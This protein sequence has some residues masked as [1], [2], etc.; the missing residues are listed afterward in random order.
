MALDRDVADRVHPVVVQPLEDGRALVGHAAG[1]L[2]G[3]AHDAQR[4]GA[5]GGGVGGVGGS[6]TPV[7]SS[8]FRV[9]GFRVCMPL[10]Y[11]QEWTEMYASHP[12]ESKGPC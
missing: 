2:G 3:L 10:E 8:G 12:V 4:D 7:G 11:G 5:P 1:R 9:S 6:V